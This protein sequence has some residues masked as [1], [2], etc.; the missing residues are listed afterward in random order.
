MP[1]ADQEM[2]N[3]LALPNVRCKTECGTNTEYARMHHFVV[4]AVFLLC[5]LPFAML[6]GRHLCEPRLPLDLATTPRYRNVCASAHTH[7]WHMTWRVWRNSLNHLFTAYSFHRRNKLCIEY[8]TRT[9]GKRN[10]IR[11]AI[12]NQKWAHCVCARACLCVFGNDG[13][14]LIIIITCSI[15]LLHFIIIFEIMRQNLLFMRLLLFTISRRIC[16]HAYANYENTRQLQARARLPD[17]A[18]RQARKIA[19]HEPIESGRNFIAS[20]THR[21]PAQLSHQ[22]AEMDRSIHT[23]SV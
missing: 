10:K 15:F 12:R 23:F 5:L 14:I 6:F 2:V 21:E 9:N 17:F 7:A 18:K 19:L 11:C 13:Y 8:I 22:W 16:C 20:L 3:G 4:Y 1:A